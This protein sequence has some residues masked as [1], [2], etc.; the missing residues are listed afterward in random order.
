MGAP[1]W[2]ELDTAEMAYELRF[3][4]L[5]P[6]VSVLSFPC[7][8]S[9]R[10]NLDGLSDTARNDYFFARTCVGRTYRAPTVSHIE[11]PGGPRRT[12]RVLCHE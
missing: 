8:Q 3:E 7:D 1:A 5:W 6:S 11:R 4:A 2:M 10:V 12:T 9:G